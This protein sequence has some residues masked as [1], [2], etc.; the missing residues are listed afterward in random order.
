MAGVG[1]TDGR[2]SADT[3]LRHTINCYMFGNM[4]I[5]SMKKGERVRWYLLAPGDSNNFH[6]PRRVFSSVTHSQ[7][8][9]QLDWAKSRFTPAIN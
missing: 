3:N 5:L 9:K 2:G 7:A 1:L 4:P 6:T 8:A